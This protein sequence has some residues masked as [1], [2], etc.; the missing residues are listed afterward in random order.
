MHHLN[1]LIFHGRSALYAV[2]FGGQRG[3]ADQNV[4]HA[5]LTAA[6]AL[7]VVTGKALYQHSGKLDL[8]V[9]ENAVV[10]NKHVVEYHQGLYAAE[11]AVAHVHLAAFQLAGVA[12]LAA[13]NHENAL[14]VG[15]YGKRNGII[16]VVWA[17]RDGGHDDHFV[18]VDDTGLVCLCAAN[19]NAVGAA[20]HHMQVHV[21]VRLCV[22]GQRTVALGVGHRAIYRP[23]VLFGGDRKLFEV[24]KI[25]GFVLLIGLKGGGIERVER[26]HAYTALKTGSG[27]LA[28]QTLHFH[29]VYQVLRA[30][31][32]MTEAVDLVPGD[33]RG[34]GH[35]IL[36]LGVLRE[37]VGHADRIQRRAQNRVIYRVLNFLAE[38]VNLQI[39]LADAFD[40]LFSGHKCHGEIPSF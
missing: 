21:G 9:E 7:S 17:H 5:D 19:N 39:Q 8:A 23:V 3:R 33:R 24:L 1:Q 26:V 2:V 29:L 14:G 30:V 15:R 6:V 10:R 25:I 32:D 18:G 36:V 35:Q 4:A 31:V 27:F 40:I 20:L 34:S 12:A 16:L 28:E 13:D 37:V 22:G 11:L 38:H